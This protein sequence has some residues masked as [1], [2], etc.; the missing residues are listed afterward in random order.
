MNNKIGL[1]PADI[2]IGKR[3]YYYPI[4]GRFNNSKAGSS[5]Y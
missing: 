2:E 4:V 1:R 3:V 5:D